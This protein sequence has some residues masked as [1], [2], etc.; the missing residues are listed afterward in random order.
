VEVIRNLIKRLNLDIEKETLEFKPQIL[1]IIQK[2][3]AVF[4]LLFNFI[5][6]INIHLAAAKL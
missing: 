4:N 1:R 2:Q 3:N 5:K 6:R